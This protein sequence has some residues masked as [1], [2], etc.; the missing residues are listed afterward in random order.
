MLPKYEGVRRTEPAYL[1]SPN[2]FALKDLLNDN[3]NSPD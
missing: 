2:E 3:L 1:M